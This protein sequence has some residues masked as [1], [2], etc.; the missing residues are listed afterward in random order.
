MRKNRIAM[1]L[2]AGILDWLSGAAEAALQESKELFGRDP[3]V[4]DDLAE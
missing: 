2:G 3:N 4:A 1:R